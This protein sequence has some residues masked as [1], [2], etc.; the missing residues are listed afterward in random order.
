MLKQRQVSL[1][2]R[3][4]QVLLVVLKQASPC[5]H[6]RIDVGSV[7]VARMATLAVGGTADV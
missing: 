4:E 2:Q 3:R 7:M 1:D 5:S 6:Y